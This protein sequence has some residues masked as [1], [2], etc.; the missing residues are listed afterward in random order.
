MPTKKPEPVRPAETRWVYLQDA[1]ARY[2]V[3]VSTQRRA[4]SR[5]GL[6]AGRL[7][8]SII[9]IRVDDLDALF[10]PIPS[11]RTITARRSA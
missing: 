2:G 7:G 4:I 5:G 8:R 9:R 6:R 1:A 3:C 10:R 11:A